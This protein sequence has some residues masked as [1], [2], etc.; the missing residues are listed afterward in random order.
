MGEEGR[1][2]VT[3]RAGVA[4]FTIAFVELLKVL[5]DRG[6]IAVSDWDRVVDA[7]TDR[8]DD[9]DMPPSHRATIE[10]LSAGCPVTRRARPR[11]NGD[12]MRQR[13][14]CVKMT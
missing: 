13:R 14:G 8:A 2:I 10:E 9:D 4:A 6:L 1:E 3:D 12:G 11:S 7:L 5:H